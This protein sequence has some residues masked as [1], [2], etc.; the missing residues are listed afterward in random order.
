[1]T[2]FEQKAHE[3]ST[4]MVDNGKLKENYCFDPFTIIFIISLIVSIIKLIQWCNSSS[5]AAHKILQSPSNYYKWQMWRKVKN[6]GLQSSAHQ[7]CYDALLAV[8]KKCTPTEVGEMYS[9]ADKTR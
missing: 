5:E 7:A 6:S 9:E 3:I 4:D 2:I 8:S 1:M